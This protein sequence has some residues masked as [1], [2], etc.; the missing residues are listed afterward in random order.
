[1]KNNRPHVVN[2]MADQL[3][4][5]VLFQGHTPNIDALAADGVVFEEAY[6]NCPLCVPARGSYFTGLY[7]NKNGSLINPWEPADAGYGDVRAGIDNLY[8]LMEEEWD[9]IH[10]GK[11]HLYTAGG[12]LEERPDS[13]TRWLSTE[14][15]Y[16][17][18]VRAQGKALPGGPQFRTRVAEMAG[19]KATKVSSYSNANTGCYE[20]GEAYYF[21]TYFTEQALA[22]ISSRD[23]MRP[24]LLNVMLLAPHPPFQIPEPWYGSVTNDDFK[25]PDNVG[26]FYPRQSPLQ[27]YNLTGA[28]G[29]RYSRD[30]W[31]ETWRVYLGLVRMLD[32]CVG[33]IIGALK[34]QGIYD[35]SL[36]IF[37]S[38][39]GEMLG[40]HA[41][42][43]KM[44]MYEEA[45]RVP[46]Y[47]KF[48][49]G[50]HTS[51]KTYRQTVSHVDVF[52][53]LCG[54][55]G[56]ET[57]NPVDGVSLLP[58][59]RGEVP[60]D[61]GRRIFIQ[62]DGNGSLS[63]FQRCLVMG[64]YKLIADLFKDEVYY[65]LY[66]LP[67]DPQETNNLIF[68]AGYDLIAG[69]MAGILAKQ[70]ND[71]GDRLTLLPFDP[72]VFRGQYAGFP[73]R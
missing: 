33:R 50:F 71:S 63:N 34:E 31:Q 62:Y 47:M 28:V 73:A 1:M 41:L 65:E 58:L 72:Q 20:E 21:D 10:S 17:E 48:P 46:L 4:R 13:K 30:E 54:Y 25:L 69:E 40:S 43:Q 26:T 5:D 6:T 51:A 56:L 70:M 38:D 8:T 7:P 67:S 61:Q 49:K 11:Q 2:I 53:T 18:Y 23:Q 59:L 16:K 57:K 12:K 36:I 35:D 3:R 27:M 14:A 39:H 29:T 19:G 45:A 55:L 15:S 9:S 68:D 66:H 44:C 60:E 42:F 37:T 22:G 52:P 24:L 32:H 64:G